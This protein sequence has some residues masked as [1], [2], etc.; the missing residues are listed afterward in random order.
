MWGNGSY[1]P[2]NLEAGTRA[3]GEVNPIT[4]FYFAMGIRGSEKLLLG[5]ME[6]APERE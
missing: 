3:V 2:R 4:Q 6:E 1:K 5:N